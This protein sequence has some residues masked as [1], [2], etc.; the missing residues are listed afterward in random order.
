MKKKN[1]TKK[2]PDLKAGDEREV[3][4]PGYPI[5]PDNED[6]YSQNKK[7]DI[8]PKDVLEDVDS[9]EDEFAETDKK[10]ANPDMYSGDLDVPGS[11]LDD[12][13]EIIGNEDEENNFYSTTDNEDT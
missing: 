6:I 3:N 4:P 5:Y 13:E 8:D 9:T 7:E 10:V 2:S 1:D 12:K 11:E